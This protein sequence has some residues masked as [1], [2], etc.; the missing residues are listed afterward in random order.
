MAMPPGAVRAKETLTPF[1]NIVA[2]VVVNVPAWP[3]YNLQIAPDVLLHCYSKYLYFPFV[4][5]MF[6]RVLYKPCSIPGC[7]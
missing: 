2:P 6:T 5:Y 4:A 7:L 1:L 3:A